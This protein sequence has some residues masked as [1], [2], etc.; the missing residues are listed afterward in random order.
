M[1][2]LN[3][4]LM[5]GNLTRD[6]VLSTTPS[7]TLVCNFSMGSHHLYR[8]DEEQRKETSFFDVEV[9]SRLGENCAEYLRKGRGVRVVGRLKQD[10]WRNG[11]GQPRSKIKIV[12]EHVEFRPMKKQ[13]EG[14]PEDVETDAQDGA[15]QPLGPPSEGDAQTIESVEE[16]SVI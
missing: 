11:E 8:K 3:S 16:L 2:D 10:R 1:N 14:N 13:A 9:W 6:P 12:A 7:G 4:I 5:E 15:G